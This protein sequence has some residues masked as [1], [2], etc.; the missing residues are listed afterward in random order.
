LDKVWSLNTA[1]G[2]LINFEVYQGSNPHANSEYEEAFG[3]C[4]APLMQMID[5]FSTVQRLP[6][7][8]YFDHYEDE[9]TPGAEE[10]RVWR[11]WYDNFK[12]MMKQP[13]SSFEHVMN[14]NG[15]V[16]AR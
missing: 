16:I 6:F 12:D 10:A 4:S 2:Y 7:C 9:F 1:S 8:F 5:E 11:N 13:R 3:R 15:I 14:N